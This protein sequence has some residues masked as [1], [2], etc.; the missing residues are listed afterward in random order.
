MKKCAATPSTAALAPP[1]NAA[2]PSN[3]LATDCITRT[4]LT[5]ARTQLTMKAADRSSI[6]ATKPP[7]RTILVPFDPVDGIV[8][9]AAVIEEFLFGETPGF[10]R[11]QRSYGDPANRAN[12][13]LL[14]SLG[15]SQSCEHPRAQNRSHRV[16]HLTACAAA[17]YP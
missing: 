2:A 9:A 10:R 15:C 14:L 13:L 17:T 4:G 6:P 16:R 7:I 1:V 3:P 12:C 11:R 8:V 5:P